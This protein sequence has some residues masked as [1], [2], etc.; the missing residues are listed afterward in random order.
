MVTDRNIRQRMASENYS[1]FWHTAQVMKV[2]AWTNVRG[3]R[4]GICI[5]FC[6]Q[7]TCSLVVQSD[8]TISIL[9]SRSTLARA[10]YWQKHCR[11]A[12]RNCRQSG[13]NSAASAENTK[14]RSDRCVA[15][16]NNICRRERQT[17]QQRR[18]RSARAVTPRFYAGARCACVIARLQ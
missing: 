1:G 18:G 16:N 10:L 17:K 14:S 7:N 11:I 6:F 13:S 2:C 9:A 4:H 12:S 5:F 8:T 15:I 3:A